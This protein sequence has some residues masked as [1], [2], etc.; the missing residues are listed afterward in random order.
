MVPAARLAVALPWP[1]ARS[2][3]SHRAGPKPV[4]FHCPRC[5]QVVDRGAAPA[6]E[7][8]AWMLIALVAAL[9]LVLELT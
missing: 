2:R 6:S 4:I 7:Q 8:V 1:V 9:A 3:T 5:K